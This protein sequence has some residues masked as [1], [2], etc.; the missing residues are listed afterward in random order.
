VAALH[1]KLKALRI[2]PDKFDQQTN[3]V[4]LAR[5]LQTDLADLER[6]LRRL[7]VDTVCDAVELRRR[8]VRM[9]M[10]AIELLG[11]GFAASP[12]GRNRL[13]AVFSV[14]FVRLVEEVARRCSR[15]QPPDPHGNPRFPAAY[16]RG[17]VQSVELHLT[18]LEDAA[19]DL[20]RKLRPRRDDVMKNLC[21]AVAAKVRSGNKKGP[22]LNFVAGAVVAAAIKAPCSAADLRTFE[23]RVG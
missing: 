23:T 15:S 17:L 2:A 5:R 9:Q 14:S 18:L 1:P 21:Q 6:R 12:Q 20:A 11:L 16:P 22:Y 10:A 4:R 7:D 8:F 19:P 3:A 13:P